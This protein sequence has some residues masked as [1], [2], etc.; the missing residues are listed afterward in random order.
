MSQIKVHSIKYRDIYNRLKEADDK[1]RLKLETIFEQV[2][3]T[4]FCI[5]S[6]QTGIYIRLN[7]IDHLSIH[8]KNGLITQIHIKTADKLIKIDLIEDK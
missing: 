2:L 8:N 7:N 6:T 1:H 4:K 3:N 5:K